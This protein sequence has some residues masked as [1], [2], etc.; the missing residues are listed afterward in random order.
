LWDINVKRAAEL[1]VLQIPGTYH[2]RRQAIDLPTS[3]VEECATADLADTVEYV[4]HSS[5]AHGAFTK[6]QRKN[7][8]RGRLSETTA[9]DPVLV[10]RGCIYKFEYPDVKRDIYVTQIAFGLVWKVHSPTETGEVLY[11]IRF[12]PPKGR[13]HKHYIEPTL[14]IRTSMRTCHST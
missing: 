5:G 2:S 1:P 11:D 13:S 7:L 3:Q 8:I 4:T 6:I 10:R 14:Y 9:D 12:C